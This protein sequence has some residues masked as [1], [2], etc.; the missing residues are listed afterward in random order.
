MVRTRQILVRQSFAFSEVRVYRGEFF[1]GFH[2][3]ILKQSEPDEIEPA[4]EV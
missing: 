4:G 3:L 2:T 1:E